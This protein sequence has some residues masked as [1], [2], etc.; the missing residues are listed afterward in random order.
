MQ[1]QSGTTGINTMRVYNPVKQ[2]YD[3]DPAGRFV[4][5]FVPELAMAP[6]AFVHEP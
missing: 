4:R 1:M 5:A 3:Q 2:D 6:D